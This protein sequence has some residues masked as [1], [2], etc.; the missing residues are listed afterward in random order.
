[1]RTRFLVT[2]IALGLTTA[3]PRNVQASE[4]LRCGSRLVLAGDTRSSV[5]HKCGEPVDVTHKTVLRRPSYVFHGRIYYG[6]EVAVDVE[7]WTYNFGPNKFMRRV[8]FVD[9]IV[10]D[11]ETLD[12]GYNED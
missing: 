11:V 8:R 10:E 3:S 6:D 5:R 9:G 12:Y 7:S 2:L 4:G 1:M